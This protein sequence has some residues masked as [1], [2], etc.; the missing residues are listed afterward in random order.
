MDDFFKDIEK[1]SSVGKNLPAWHG[2]LYL[3]FH[4]GT[5]T[6]H[7]SIKKGNRK[8]EI[9]LRDVELVATLAS[10]LQLNKEYTYPK[11]RIDDNWERLLLCQ[12]HD[13]LPGSSIGMV[14]D[15]AEEI[16]AKIK[17]DSKELLEDALGSLLQSSIAFSSNEP[18]TISSPGS[19]VAFNTT[20]FPRLDVVK[21]PLSGSGGSKLRSKV[22]QASEDGAHGYALM[23][24]G[25][26]LGLSQIR[27]LYA[28]CKAA[29]VLTT[30]SGDFI[31]RNSAVQLTI[32]KGR[33]TS[34]IDNQL[35]CVYIH[36]FHLKL[37]RVYLIM[38]FNLMLSRELIYNG[39]TG[40]MVVF[41]D[42]PNY[43][44]AWGTFMP[45]T[46]PHHVNIKCRCRNPPFGVPATFAVL[47]RA[48]RREGPIARLRQR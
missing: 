12:F 33:I 47:K 16:Y 19:V 35:G 44:D 10:V 22:V 13:V 4:R 29:S 11:Q 21:I 27:G 15:D 14:Y 32:S 6:S 43:W 2:E 45:W 34:L 3:E 20:M 30:Q 24:A 36:C 38:F 28:D 40:G 9:L 42:R 26:G 41:D 46:C 1:S 31:L 17:E 7:G 23:E 18:F 37:V 8:S 48:G 39:E 25:S 5:Y